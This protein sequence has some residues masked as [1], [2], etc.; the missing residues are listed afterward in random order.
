MAQDVVV[1]AMRKRE[2]EVTALIVTVTSPVA[3]LMTLE[4]SLLVLPPVP[5]ESFPGDVPPP[6]PGESFPGDV[7]KVPVAPKAKAT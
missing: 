4:S 6:V 7:P 3:S 1:V 5:G 2:I